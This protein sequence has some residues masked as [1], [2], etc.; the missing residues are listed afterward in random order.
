[1]FLEQ[2]EEH[3]ERELRRC[4]Q[5]YDTANGRPQDVLD[6]QANHLEHCLAL[7]LFERDWALQCELLCWL[8]IE[9]RE[10]DVGWLLDQGRADPDARDG[11]G[12]PALVLAAAHGEEGTV[13]LL[14]GASANLEQRN[15]EGAS[16][17]AQV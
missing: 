14:V 11:D 1:M 6:Q 10:Y 16:P 4:H 7:S 3:G 9:G 17:L 5:A 8:I 12:D 13:R 15:R 2:N